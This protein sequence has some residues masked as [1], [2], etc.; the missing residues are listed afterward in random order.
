M[1][2]I[3]YTNDKLTYGYYDPYLIDAN[4][5]LI[6]VNGKTNVTVTGLGFVD[7]G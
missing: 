1:N 2:G 5:K 3:D 7:S 6:N 4:P